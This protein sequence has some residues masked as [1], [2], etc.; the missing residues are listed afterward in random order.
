MAQLIDLQ[1]KVTCI[2]P[3]RDRREWLK[4]SIACFEAQTYRN[5][6]LLIIA[7][8]EDRVDDL[9]PKGDDRIM[10]SWFYPVFMDPLPGPLQ[11]PEGTGPFYLN[12]GQKR[13]VA[14]DRARGD[15][16]AHWDDDDYYAPGRIEDQVNRLKISGKYVTGYSTMKF[17]DGADWWE[18]AGDTQYGIGSSLMYFKEYWKA[19]PFPNNHTGED[20]AFNLEA[21]ASR[22]IISVDCRDM[23]YVNNHDGNTVPREMTGRQWKKLTK[24]PD[25]QPIDAIKEI[26]LPGVPDFSKDL[27]RDKL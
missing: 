25:W 22:S 12:I 10:I 15:I 9:I 17:T 11:D 27:T 16:I 6:E 13:N 24:Q 23:M 21:M 3:T 18:W 1:P 8:G 26:R 4:K 19:H 7:D 14:C 20:L 5:L 2:C